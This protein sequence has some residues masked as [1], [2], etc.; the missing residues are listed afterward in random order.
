MTPPSFRH[1]AA[2]PLARGCGLLAGALACWLF[3]LLGARQIYP[4]ARAALALEIVFPEAVVGQ[5]EPIVCTGMWKEGD[6]LTVE[7]LDAHTLVFRYDHWGHGGPSTAPIRF[8]PGLRRTLRIEMPSLITY[9]KPA[10]GSRAPLRLV[11]DGREIFHADVAYHGR[12]PKQ[13]FFGENPIGASAAPA[14]RGTLFRAGSHVVRGG[15]ET[16]FT[17][18]ERMLRWF[19]KQ[20]WQVA[21]SLLAG[22]AVGCMVWGGVAWQIAHPRPPRTRRL[23]IHGLASPPLT[24]R[25]ALAA[26]RWFAVA[27]ALATVGYAWLVTLGSFQVIYP[28]IFGSFYDYQAQS[29]LRGHLDVPE[30]AIQGEAFEARGKLYGYFGPTPALLRLPFVALGLAFGEL[31]R[32]FM[33]LYFLGS[34][35]A[36]YLLLRDATKLARD[37]TVHGTAE[38][39]CFATAVMVASAGFGSTIF[40]LGSRGLIFHEAILAG[41]TFALWSVWCALRFLQTPARRWWVSALIC[42][43]LSVHSRPPTGLFAL[44]LL[45]C[46]VV[47]LLAGSWRETSIAAGRRLVLP[48]NF[49]KLFG[50]GLLCIVGQLTLNGL[51]YLKFRT[52]DPAP[53]RISRPYSTPGRL[54]HIDGKSFHTVNLP[55]NF[56][57]YLVRP[58]FHLEH[59]FPWIYLQS[60]IP[61]RHFPK[62]KID[63]PDHTLAVPFAMPSLFVLAT[64]GS[65]AAAFLLWNHR[66]PLGLLWIAV[67]P[68]TLAL[69][70]AIATAQRYTGDFVPFLV[71]SGAFGLA[72]FE[73]TPRLLRTAL[74]T[75]LAVFTAAAM[76]VTV[77]ITLHYQGDYLWGVPE[78][79]RQNYRDLRK[80]VDALF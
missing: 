46:V 52:F 61:G 69:F 48:S 31:S 56:Y 13:L 26:H 59:G 34:L 54:E 3:V 32:L 62:A 49:R 71:A 29:F 12:L 60:P 39:S 37:G 38:P 63:L 75:L 27:A 70:A 45:G 20:P 80:N 9:Q 19:R 40:F 15:P 17:T 11:L 74:R 41:I 21:G 66:L 51:A 43:L 72:A 53:L 18:G 14:F 78:P 36:A 73:Q 6:V 16:Y 57:T 8:H 35:I 28:E 64:L 50:I 4:P 7:Y 33:V 65:L 25:Q 44:T 47:A 55:Y 5:R 2:S 67:L 76:A 22:M 24:L 42:G 1:A 77:A 10:V 30:E 23:A 58:N 79:V 68:M